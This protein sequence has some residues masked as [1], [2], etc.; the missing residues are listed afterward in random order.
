MAGVRPRE[1][2]VMRELYVTEPD[3][4]DV[5]EVKRLLP[6]GMFTV[7]P[8]QAGFAPGFTSAAQALLIRS[9]TTVDSSI[10]QFFPQLR[11]VIRVGTGLDNVDVGY[12]RSAGIEVF[13]AAGANADAVAE[14]VAAMILYVKRGLYRLNPEDVASWNRFAFRGQSVEGQT[15][16]IVGFGHIGRLLQRKLA[17]L[18]CKKFLAYDPYVPADAIA[19]TGAAAADLSAVLRESDIVSLHLPLL[20][21]TH[22]I[23][24]AEKLEML[25]DG[26]LLINAARGGI[27]DEAALLAAGKNITYVA[28]TVE[29]EPKINP[30][31]LKRGNV[32]VTP[33]IASLTAES[34]RAMLHVALANYL[35]KHL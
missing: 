33:H 35:E 8:G 29:N 21:E 14:Y 23:I 22:H 13:N 1:A 34:E 4:I 28:D 25:K 19:E 15:V 6:D 7:T 24:N 5:N 18:G 9:D 31:L 3:V 16:G 26:A 32:I 12:C 11:A 30:A 27:V 2:K 17:G 10:K 20:P